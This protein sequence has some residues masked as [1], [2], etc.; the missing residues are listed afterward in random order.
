MHETEDVLH[1]VSS[2]LG[3]R[4]DINCVVRASCQTGPQ[5]QNSWESDMFC[6]FSFVVLH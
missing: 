6:Y 3:E 4:F 5:L 1:I 2:T